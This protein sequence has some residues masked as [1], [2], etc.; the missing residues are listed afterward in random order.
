M[1]HPSARSLLRL[2]TTLL[3]ALSLGALMAGP[4]A[5][6]DKPLADQTVRMLN[7]RFDPQTVTVRAGETVTWVNPSPSTH[8]ATSDAPGF[9]VT[10]SPG[11]SSGPVRFNTPGTFRYHCEIHPSMTGTVTVT[12]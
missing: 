9:D 1:P 10:V 8:T 2:L 4:T 6:T 12:P 3:A 7:F 5:A 11:Q